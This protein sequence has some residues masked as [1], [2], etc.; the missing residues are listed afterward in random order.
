MQQILLH[1]RIHKCCVHFKVFRVDPQIKSNLSSR[2]L[3][4]RKE[5][6]LTFLVIWRFLRLELQMCRKKMTE[7]L[8]Y[9]DLW[10]QTKKWEEANIHE[11]DKVLGKKKSRKNMQWKIN[12]LPAVQVAKNHG[13]G[14]QEHPYKNLPQDFEFFPP[15]ST[16]S[17]QCHPEKYTKKFS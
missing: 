7:S 5:H 13:V 11:M 4:L 1:F 14:G 10:L 6:V 2:S 16:P 8:S 9:R 17:C 15:I 3:N 12:W